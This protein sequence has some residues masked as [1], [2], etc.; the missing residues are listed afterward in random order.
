MP[1]F[2]DDPMKR[3]GLLMFG[4]QALQ[5]LMGGGQ[6]QPNNLLRNYML[7]QQMKQQQTQQM[8]LQ[9]QQKVQDL[10]QASAAKVVG[11]WDPMSKI[12]WN[13]GRQGGAVGA[14]GTMPQG[15]VMGAL[16]QMQQQAGLAMPV[17]TERARYVG[18][19][20][21]KTPQKRY[22][23][24]QNPY[25]RGGYGQRETT[26]GQ[27]SG[28]QG[29]DKPGTGPFEGKALDAQDSNILLKGDPSSAKYGLAYYRQF[30]IP[31]MV[32]T[33]NGMVPMLIPA[34]SGIRPPTG[35]GAKAAQKVQS[36]QGGPVA[37]V[38]VPGT[39]KRPSDAQQKAASYGVRLQSSNEIITQNEALGAE[40]TGYVSGSDVFPNVM[41]SSER[42]Q[43][44]QAER[45]FINAQLRR[46]S[47]AVIADTEFENAA[48]QYFPQPGDGPEVIE[49][50]RRAR[51]I[52]ITNMGQ[53]AGRAQRGVPAPSEEAPSETV[54]TKVINGKTYVKIGDQWFEEGQ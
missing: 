26:T 44:E 37:G 29:P 2:L 25:G 28:Y 10:G 7:M 32:M 4:S 14:P 20:A 21:A 39:A 46:E 19:L 9:E 36:R 16:P 45:D 17:A 51:D 34:P 11:G 38:A 53:E 3:M 22:E 49:Q 42:Q 43:L 13:Q 33:E 18:N 54:P 35:G 30:Q 47:G 27:I 50:K 48:Q 8:G 40:L 24:V 52:A 12:Q 5:G 15:G 1:G 31:K 6:Q 41:K 23:D